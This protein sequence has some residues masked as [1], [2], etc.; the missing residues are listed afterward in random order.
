MSKLNLLLP[1]LLSVALLP[2]CASN[3]NP[4]DTQSF[5][6]SVGGR[7]M[8]ST[9]TTP[10]KQAG[11]TA[12]QQKD[13]ANAKVKLEE[14]LNAKLDDPEARI[15]LNNAIALSGNH[16]KLAVVIPGE[17][18][19]GMSKEIL[20]GVA[21]SQQET[22]QNSGV[23]G[24]QI[25]YAIIADNDNVDTGKE[26]AR[27]LVNEKEILGVVGHVSSG[28]TLA[29]AEIY[30][31][32]KLVAISPISSAVQL[33]NKSPYVFRTIP[34]DAI[35]GKTLAAHIV[36]QNRKAAIVFF[37]SESE[38]SKSLKAEFTNNLTQNNGRV[39]TEVDIANPN[40][41]AAQSLEQATKQ[42]ADHIFLAANTGTLDR[43][44][45]VITA[46]ALRLPI[47]AGDAL[48]SPKT[49]DISRQQSNGMVIAVP[50][51]ILADL[52]STFPDRAQ[53]LWK[54]DVSWRTVTSYDA[55]QAL[56][57]G[58]KQSPTR[59]GIQQV[60]SDPKFEAIGG[61]Q[62]VKFVPGGDRRSSIQLVTVAPGKRSSYGFDF[63]PLPNYVKPLPDASMLPD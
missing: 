12:I 45:Q 4:P 43:A 16:F 5:Q 6:G 29:A 25:V 38:Y 48:Y 21:Q 15:Y 32:G 39:V 3:T 35:A 10:E 60:L 22:N 63:I 50:W 20:R 17:S 41:S 9:P 47:V 52:S 1:F 30:G 56:I 13:Y 33:S 59:E 44:L 51:H 7:L 11:I 46:N 24:N 8:I 61:E 55:S 34:S 18:D 53:K 42:G 62:S 27:S 28:V 31:S 58:L 57:A 36:K 40:F 26:V 2:S 14:S 37:N 49:L 23:N 54:G 19:I